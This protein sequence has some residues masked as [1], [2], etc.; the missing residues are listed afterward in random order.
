[1]PRLQAINPDTAEGRAKELLDGVK[2]KLGK[3]PNLLRTMANSPAVLEAYLGL[4]GALAGGL[5]PA[6]LREQLALSVSEANGCEY[7]LAA[8]SALGKMAGLSEEDVLESR[9]GESSDSKARAALSFA[10]EVVENR[11]WVSDGDVE[12]LRSAGY[13]DGEI[14]EIVAHVALNIFTNY[15]NNVAQTVVD[16]PSVPKLASR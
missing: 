5:L 8:H 2:A 10:R 11:G 14:A 15:F 16:F 13:G 12:G 9:G 1:M 4:S 7:C 3:A 6:K